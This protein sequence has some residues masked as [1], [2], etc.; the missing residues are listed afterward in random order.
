MRERDKKK[1]GRERER[2]RCV[3]GWRGGGVEERKLGRKWTG[4]CRKSRDG[5]ASSKDFR[6]VSRQL[7]PPFITEGTSVPPREPPLSS[8]LLAFPYWRTPPYWLVPPYWPEPPY[9]LIPPYWLKTPFGSTLPT[10]S[11]LPHP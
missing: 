11:L 4:Q 6:R 2:E 3:S 1:D 9:W 5:W 7:Q 8:L 10:A